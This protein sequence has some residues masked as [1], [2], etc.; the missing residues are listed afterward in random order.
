MSVT[1]GY[2]VTLT[3]QGFASQLL[4]SHLLIAGIGL[5]V[6][7]VALIGTFF[8]RSSMHTILHEWEPIDHTGSKLRAEVHRSLAG[9]RGWVALGDPDQRQA[10]NNAWKYGID[11]ILTNLLTDIQDL[12]D[13][14]S[15]KLLEQLPHLARKLYISQWHVQDVA[16][17]PGNNLVTTYFQQ[18]IEPIASEL[19]RI[20]RTL[21]EKFRKENTLNHPDLVPLLRV[22]QSFTLARLELG[23]YLTHGF[24]Q[25]ET[26]FKE[27]LQQARDQLTI[28]VKQHPHHQPGQQ[29]LIKI[30]QEQFQIMESLVQNLIIL[31][32]KEQWNI[33]QVLMKKE[34]VPLARE[35][36]SV[37]H[38]LLSHSRT[39]VDQN[40]Q[41][42]TFIST[43]SI[44]VLLFLTIGMLM[45]AYFISKRR[46]FMLSQPVLNLLH[47][48]H[49]IARGELD[50]HVPITTTDELGEL[51]LSFNRMRASLQHYITEQ[52]TI[53][54][55]LRSSEQNL[56]TAQEIAHLGSWNWDI[57][58]NT[59]SWS[60]ETYRIFGLQPQQIQANYP[61]FLNAVHPDDRKKVTQ[62]IEASLAEPNTPYHIEHR[63]VHPDGSERHVDEV[64]KVV[65]D[66]KGEPIH[67]LGTVLDISKH[68]M[69]ESDLSKA[70]TQ[71]T[72]KEALLQAI[73]DNALDAII[74][75]DKDGLI[76]AF[77]PAAEQ[78]FGYATH[79][80]I[81][82]DVAQLI[83]P[84]ELREAHT[85]AL[86]QHARQTHGLPVVK[87]RVEVPGKRADGKIIDLQVGLTA[88]HQDGNIHYAGFLQDITDR[89]QLLISLQDTLEVAE[90][91]NRAK[92]EFLANMSHEIRSPM[93]AI[94]G[95]TELVLSSNL[96]QDQRENLEIVQNSSHN[97]LGLIN[98]ILDFSK[99][100]AGQLTL[101]KLPF[102]LRG[103]VEKSCES[104]A[105]QLHKKGV[106]LYCDIDMDIPS[107]VGDPLRL[108]Q[109]LVNLVN[110]AI[111]FTHQGEVVVRVAKATQQTGGK[112]TIDL[113]FSV[114]D[115][116]IG[117][118]TDRIN[119][120]FQRFTQAD[121][122]TTRKYGGT[123]L[124]LTISRRLVTMMNGQIWV[125]SEVDKGSVFHFSATLG[126]GQRIS[127]KDTL[128][129]KDTP[130]IGHEQRHHTIEPTHLAGVRILI[131]D[132]NHTG[133][134]IIKK[135][136]CHYQ[137]NVEETNK[138]TTVLEALKVA[139]EKKQPFDIILLDHS[140]S[141]TAKLESTQ[142]DHALEQEQHKIMMV[143]VNTQLGNPRPDHQ[144]KHV[145]LLKKPVKLH[146]LLNKIDYTLGRAITK[147]TGKNAE[148]WQNHPPMIPLRILLVE[149][150]LNNQKLA[151]SI[152]E[153]AGHYVVL[154]N[155]GRE[156]LEQLTT[157]PFD[158][159]LMDLHMPEMDG[160]S[161]TEQIR[162]G[163]M[164]T[165]CDPQIP[166]IA[167]T[168]HAMQIEEKKCLKAGMNGYLRKP[169]RANEL[170][171]I[172]RP[173]IKDSV[174]AR[175]CNR[176]DQKITHANPQTQMEKPPSALSATETDKDAGHAAQQ[177]FLQDGPEQLDIL[178]QSIHDQVLHDTLKALEKI[179]KMATD[180]GANRLR[181]QAIRLKGKAE[182]NKWD[183]VLKIFH[184]L[185][186]EFHSSFKAVDNIAG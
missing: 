173:F 123:G 135:M 40:A 15:R 156:A 77:N 89:K 27:S 143:H 36:L 178:Q 140:L 155:H 6:V 98:D 180:V 184:H 182:L 75:I 142:W 119:D 42:A 63:V 23:N 72:N 128:A 130:N 94:M 175:E 154:V 1:K 137:A 41:K 139:K 118:P 100:E 84:T 13:T 104:L 12:D 86:Q 51:T 131:G 81:G 97:L 163:V 165:H 91:A 90:T 68:K 34:T 66:Q 58:K 150:L 160:Y 65:R 5:L 44:V 111:K 148:S 110:N 120:I 73:L 29:N 109:I 70:N 147:D 93:N 121:G 18:E 76:N 153:Q 10:W 71:L 101:E 78:L 64:G 117:I 8:L 17:T 185:K 169:Y 74:T 79:E 133:R 170:L 96:S 31:R 124:G 4:R 95:M 7:L 177:A 25:H 26:Q 159:I 62:A 37:L 11:P 87:R 105:F 20:F 168:A 152:L 162:S 54:T 176:L 21:T 32:K 2:H 43:L 157:E 149:D 14:K 127:S 57:K 30:I 141:T 92:S 115:T 106:E 122:S 48:A 69:A 161:A 52:K 114:A 107:L 80:A 19:E 174:A 132:G 171:G 116:G 83:I 39:M 103:R 167:V 138:V 181:I 99:I 126:I 82:Q 85:Q 172:I 50:H 60:D 125:E 136:L 158:L 88:I 166:I 164:Q 113:H 33:A 183:E 53:A 22:Y 179:K 45:A 46:A 24:E 112:H 151:T 67:M 49:A 129:S 3:G 145:D 61:A 35:V 16:Q 108:N 56:A 47:S 38:H 55:A 9:L 134:T 102:D 28:W 59:L 144:A 146:A 186:Q